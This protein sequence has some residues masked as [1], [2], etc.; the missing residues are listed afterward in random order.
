MEIG[1]I[2]KGNWIIDPEQIDFGGLT[3]VAFNSTLDDI[4]FYEVAEP[5]VLTIE[6]LRTLRFRKNRDGIYYRSIN[7]ACVSYSF[8][9]NY[10]NISFNDNDIKLF[11]IKSLHQLQNAIWLATGKDWDYCEM[12]DLIWYN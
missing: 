10:L 1:E 5:A 6:L 11:E 8:E 9:S 3:I 4:S 7:K 12:R 2:R